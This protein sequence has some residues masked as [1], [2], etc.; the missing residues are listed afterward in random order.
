MAQ[1]QK[2]EPLLTKV[3]GGVALAQPV[4]VESSMW[5]FSVAD[6][7]RFGPWLVPR[8]VEARRQPEQWIGAWLRGL[9]DSNEHLFLAQENSVGL[10]EIYRPGGVLDPMC[11]R[12]RFVF[13]KTSAHVKEASAFYPRFLEWARSLGADSLYVAV[14]SD[15]SHDMIRDR[16]GGRLLQQVQHFLKL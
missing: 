1:V 6:L 3:G 14:Q 10:A 15:V 8:L 2:N 13:A 11:V 12:E 9:I 5:R 16:T 7:T 4:F